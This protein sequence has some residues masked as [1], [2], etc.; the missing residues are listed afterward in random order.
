MRQYDKNYYIYPSKPDPMRKTTLSFLIILLL[1]LNACT[2]H[3]DG[4][5]FLSGDFSI[6][7]SENG[8]ISSLYD[9]DNGREHLL[10]DSVSSLICMR[11]DGKMLQPQ[12]VVY[13]QKEN[14]LYFSFSGDREVKV[15]VDQH[16]NYLAFELYDIRS[17]TKPDLLIWGPFYTNISETIGETVGVVRNSDFALGIQSLNPKTLGGYPWLENDVMPEMDYFDQENYADLKQGGI[18]HT[19][20]RIEAARPV[21]DGSVLHAYCRDRYDDRSVINWG[22]DNYIVK[23]FDDGGLIGSSLALFGCKPEHVL[24]TIA[25]IEISEGLPHPEINGEWSKTASQASSAY[26]IMGFGEEDFD[27][28]LAYTEQAGLK[29]LYHSGPFET[30][31]HFILNKNFFPEGR[32]SLKRCVEKAE[33]KGISIGLHTLSNFIT[34]NDAYVTPLPDKRLAE[35]G[36]TLLSSDIGP[37]DNTITIKDPARFNQFRNNSLKAVRIADEIIRYAAV[38]ETEPWI[39]IDCQRGAFGT[40]A[41]AHAI[42]E[43]IF[44]LADHAYKVFLS[45]PELT[46]EIAENIANLYNETGVR[47]ISFDGLEG[48][49]ST[50]LG[51]YGEIL[52]ISTWYNHLNEDIQAHYIADA[53]RS[54]HYFWHIFTRMNWGEPWYAGFR[55]SQTQYRLKNQKYFDR[56]YIPNMLGWFLMKPVTSIEDIEWLLARSA[57]FNAGYAFVTSYESL[58]KNGYT[59]EILAAIS[60]WEDARMNGVFTAGQKK[61]MEDVNNEFHLEKASDTTLLLTRI[62][63]YRIKHENIQKQPGEP[64]SSTLNFDN[65]GEEQIIQFIISANKSTLINPQL[66]FDGNKLITIPVKLNNGEHLKFD[67]QFARIYSSEWQL[68]KSI[69]LDK[70]KLTLEP[71]Q[72]QMEV[73]CDFM[74]ID[75]GMLIEL[76]LKGNGETIY[77]N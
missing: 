63:P 30:W 7:I 3:K 56:N 1:L 53:S 10:S 69:S 24:S 40:T 21:Q 9:L 58:E 16:V 15:K 13:Q 71:G 22:Y 6:T 33:E 67:G 23:A 19:L 70:G 20:Y 14:L 51:N 52:F 25:D 61:L 75:G 66:E 4:I 65:P 2:T 59:N 44:K 48:C 76:R 73:S 47:Q 35:V 36:Y 55:E 60:L 38:S 34:T 41:S 68:L 18:A 64:V 57:A 62:H 45:N 46:F 72:H 29:Y 43:P 26:M 32:R 54:S 12:S 17:E 27:R 8:N 50:G 37:A 74:G 39:L 11:F 49:R 77:I 42:N 5:E 28:A 31:G